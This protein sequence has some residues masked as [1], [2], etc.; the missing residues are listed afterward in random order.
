MKLNPEESRDV[1]KITLRWG[2]R[3]ATAITVRHMCNG[4]PLAHQDERCW[5]R[6][7]SRP[8]SHRK[9]TRVASP[10]ALEPKD[11]VCIRPCKFRELGRRLATRLREDSGCIS[12]KPG[13]VARP[14][15]RLGGHIG[16][17]RFHEDL[18]GRGQARCLSQFVIALEGRVA[19]EGE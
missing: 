11:A 14:P 7:R 3:T 19:R 13:L 1:G 9:I 4:S 10:L 15:E 17:I 16:S 6:L 18:L 2:T 5:M 12:H 8:G